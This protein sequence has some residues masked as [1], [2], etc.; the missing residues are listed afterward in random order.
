MLLTVGDGNKKGNVRKT[1]N[2]TYLY[3]IGVIDR[4]DTSLLCSS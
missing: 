2:L 4:H 1:P 3:Q